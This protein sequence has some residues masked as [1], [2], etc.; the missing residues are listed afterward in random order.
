[1]ADVV[2][3][4]HQ[5]QTQPQSHSASF[6]DANDNLN[7]N[8]GGGTPVHQQQLNG[9]IENVLLKSNIMAEILKFNGKIAPS[10]NHFLHF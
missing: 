5:P 1:M 8:S 6:D 4:E 2:G 9:L 3:E 7:H 10:Q